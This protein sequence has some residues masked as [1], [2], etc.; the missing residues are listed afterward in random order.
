MRKLTSIMGL[1]LATASWS[2]TGDTAA[3]L[4]IA[5]WQ[6]QQVLY[7]EYGPLLTMETG[8]SERGIP[9]K[10]KFTLKNIDDGRQT[11]FFPKERESIARSIYIVNGRSTYFRPREPANRFPIMELFDEFVMEPGEETVWEFDVEDLVSDFSAYTEATGFLRISF[12]SLLYLDRDGD[13]EDLVDYERLRERL[14]W[15]GTL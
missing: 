5:E 13:A 8:V 4:V 11:I 10:L 2:A 7:S 3:D 9:L 6:S 1:I 14:S 12:G 15:N